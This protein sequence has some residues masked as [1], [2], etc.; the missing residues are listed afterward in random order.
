MS[1]SAEEIRTAAE[2]LFEAERSGKQMGLLSVTHP[3][4][5]LDDAYAIQAALVER[6]CLVLASLI[7]LT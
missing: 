3:S 1:L 4:I 2:A 5:T 7:L 6:K